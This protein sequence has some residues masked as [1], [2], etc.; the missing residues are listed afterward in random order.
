MPEPT[1]PN[2][3]QFAPVMRAGKLLTIAKKA[4]PPAV[5]KVNK[6]L[7]DAFSGKNQSKEAG[8]LKLTIGA[9]KE[10]KTRKQ[11]RSKKQK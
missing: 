7:S 2:L 5:K 3:G 1:K 8:A 10:L 6:V 11:R 9:A 4:V